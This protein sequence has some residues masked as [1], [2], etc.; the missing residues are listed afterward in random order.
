MKQLFVVHTQYNL[1]LATGLAYGTSTQN[2]LILFKD[3]ALTEE[4]QQRLEEL[5]DRVLLLEGNFPKKEFKSFQKYWKIK[6]DC[7]AIKTFINEAY[8]RVFIVDDVCVQE[9]ATIKYAYN[10]NHACEF[11]WLEDGSNA[12]F[13]NG[14]PSRGL[15]RNAFLRFVRKHLL[16]CLYGLYGFYDLGKCFGEH[17]LLTKL[18]VTF[19]DYVRDELKHKDKREITQEQFIKGMQFMYH[20]KP[21]YMFGPSVVFAMDKLSV[22]GNQLSIVD[23]IISQEVEEALKIGKTV[24]CKYHPRETDKLPALSQAAE[25]DSKIAMEYYLTNTTDKEMT[26]IG[27]K[28]TS[29]QVAKKMGYHVISLAKTMNESNMNVLNFYKNIGITIK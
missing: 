20:G 11:A 14:A 16:S 2:D 7:D 9:M 15:G 27:F 22:Y 10:Q 28:S 6:N 1:I 4:L 17:R 18:Y 19:P 8:E 13:H 26:L 29:L 25:L 5:F 23:K 21:Y 24:Y 12:Y 3:F